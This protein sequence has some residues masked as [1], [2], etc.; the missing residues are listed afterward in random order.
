MM[1]MHTIE[2][3]YASTTR[4]L[5]LPPGSDLYGGATI[6]SNSVEIAVYGIDASL[7]SENLT[8]RIDFAVQIMSV[9]HVYTKP[10]IVLEKIESDELVPLRVVN[11]NDSWRTGDVW[12]GTIPAEILAATHE[13]K[14]LPFQLV[15]RDGDTVINSK[16]TITLATTR[17]IDATGTVARLYEP[18]VMYRNDSWGWEPNFTYKK[19]AVVSYQGS[20]Y[21]S[22]INDNL[23][24]VPDDT[25]GAWSEVSGG[26]G[27]GSTVTIFLNGELTSDPAFYAPLF[28]GESDQVLVSRGAHHAPEWITPDPSVS[29]MLNGATTDDPAFYAPLD[30]GRAHQILMSQGSQEAPQW[31]AINRTFTV[32][33]GESGVN[34]DLSSNDILENWPG[35]WAFPKLEFFD[36]TGNPVHLAYTWDSSSNGGQGENNPPLNLFIYSNIPG[37]YVMR[38][39]VMY[40]DNVSEDRIENQEVL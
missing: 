4:Q 18:Y 13:Y 12:K 26:G 19:G 23:N 31:V 27:G 14:K 24:H 33:I 8:A 1:S 6:D 17:A 2:V 37:T 21:V 35:P 25:S 39:T 30:S 16:N 38:S 3:I 7:F 9:D 11:P 22:L 28:S 29:I 15:L 10:F 36:T 32:T 20:L 40:S 34:Q 5:S